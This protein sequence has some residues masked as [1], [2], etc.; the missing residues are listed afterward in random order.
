VG[1]PEAVEEPWRPLEDRRHY[2]GAIRAGRFE[3]TKATQLAD[4]RD[5]DF[6][7]VKMELD[8]NQ[9]TKYARIMAKEIPRRKREKEEKVAI[10]KRRLRE[11]IVIRKKFDETQ[12]ARRVEFHKWLKSQEELAKKE[13]GAW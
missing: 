4:L 1:I 6:K 8:H 3:R 11:E 12:A 2:A 9:K 7:Q 10:E 5:A 13:K